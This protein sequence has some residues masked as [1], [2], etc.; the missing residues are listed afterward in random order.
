VATWR[1]QVSQQQSWNIC[2][3]QRATFF[4]VVT[5][6]DNYQH[7]VGMRYRSLE[8]DALNYGFCSLPQ[9]EPEV[10]PTLGSSR[11]NQPS[12][13]RGQ[14]NPRPF[15]VNTNSRVLP[16]TTL[17]TDSVMSHSTVLYS[18]NHSPLGK[19]G[20]PCTKP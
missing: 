14:T 10:K 9:S 4:P 11:S 5:L 16:P 1:W 2:P 8:S 17:V 3:Q 19:N 12:R 13:L 6:V 20:N 15:K 7:Q 18:L